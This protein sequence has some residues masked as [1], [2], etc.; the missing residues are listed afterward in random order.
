M[1]KFRLRFGMRCN[2]GRDGVGVA[3]GIQMQGPGRLGCCWVSCTA[4]DDADG[5]R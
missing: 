2:R 4:G 5:L 1:V 3:L